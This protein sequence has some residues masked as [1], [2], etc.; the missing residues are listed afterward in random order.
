MEV[1]QWPAQFMLSIIFP[2]FFLIQYKIVSKCRIVCKPQLVVITKEKLSNTNKYW[3]CNSPIPG[4]Y[5]RV[6][7]PILVSSIYVK[8]FIFRLHL[9][10]KITGC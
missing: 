3:R 2:N 5:W 6:N 1:Q 10:V 8:I 7:Y 4:G 9:I